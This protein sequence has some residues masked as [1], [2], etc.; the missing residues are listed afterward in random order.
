MFA[1]TLNSCAS[2]GRYA[3]SADIALGAANGVAINNPV[4]I[5]N[6]QPS[7]YNQD[8]HFRGIVV[9][10]NEFTQ[11]LV[12]GLKG[13]V[14][15]NKGSVSDNADKELRVS[16]TKVMM[17]VKDF[18]YRARILAEVRFGDDGIEQFSVSRASY[19]SPFMV[20]NFP[21]KPLDAAFR[22][23]VEEIINNREIQN[24]INL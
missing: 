4:K 13:E 12:D 6:D 8:L 21:V 17:K 18:N 3:P 2:V 19:G 9:N 15:R 7:T 24:Y 14:I 5:T 11:S 20:S 23:L 1:A 16:V 22:N 10:Y